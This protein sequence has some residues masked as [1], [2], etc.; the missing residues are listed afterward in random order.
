[1]IWYKYEDFFRY[2]SIAIAYA[3]KWAE[4]KT[5]C[6]NITIVTA[7]FL[8]NHIFTRFGYILTIVID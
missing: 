5:L 4:A 3:T 1:M 2:I 6:T 8:Y 7:K